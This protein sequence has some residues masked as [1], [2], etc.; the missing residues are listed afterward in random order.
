MLVIQGNF[1]GEQ[2]I[3]IELKYLP[4]DY[5]VAQEKKKKTQQ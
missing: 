3:C 2:D 4:T 5:L 1:E